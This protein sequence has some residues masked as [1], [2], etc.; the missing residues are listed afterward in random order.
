MNTDWKK[1]EAD[2]AEFHKRA[3]EIAPLIGMQN[4]SAPTGNVVFLKCLGHR[5]KGIHL[6]FASGPK[7][8][9]EVSGS[10]PRRDGPTS[11]VVIPRDCGMSH[12]GSISVALSRNAES[13][14]ADIRRK[15]ILNYEHA[16]R[17]V[18]AQIKEWNLYNANRASMMDCIAKETG[19]TVLPLEDRDRPPTI[20]LSSPNQSYSGTVKAGVDQTVDISLH[21]ITPDLAIEVIKLVKDYC[22]LR[23]S[24][25]LPQGSR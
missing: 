1:Y 19:C 10:W 23:D 21:W 18:T 8:R 6:M 4:V 2:K 5:D 7:P 3:S 14:V 17:K 25:Q 12:P 20:N 9:I 16:Y 22:D 13:I 15:F 11:P 24:V